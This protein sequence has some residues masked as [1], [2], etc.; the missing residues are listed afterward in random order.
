MDNSTIQSDP[1]LELLVEQGHLTG[2]QMSSIAEEHSDSDKPVKN[3]VVDLGLL[4]EDQV[5]EII[6]GYMGSNVVNLPAID[7]PIDI[8]HRIPASVARMYN[9][10]PVSMTR[11]GA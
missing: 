10:V 6:A 9:V 7:I 11:P 1:L 3:I 5:L 4:E 2:E 8:I